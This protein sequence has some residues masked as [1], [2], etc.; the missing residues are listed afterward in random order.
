[1]SFRQDL[2]ARPL[3]VSLLGSAQGKA[4]QGEDLTVLLHSWRRLTRLCQEPQ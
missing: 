1:M 4:L 2:E 3:L